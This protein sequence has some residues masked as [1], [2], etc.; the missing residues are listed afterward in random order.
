[1]VLVEVVIEAVFGEGGAVFFRVRS[2]CWSNINNANLI[3]SRSG[4]C[5]S[6]RC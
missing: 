1:M 5:S 2:R 6:I 3:K 4:F